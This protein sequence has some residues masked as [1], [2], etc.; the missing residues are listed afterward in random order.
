MSLFTG[1][2]TPATDSAPDGVAA[3]SRLSRSALFAANSSCR[4][5]RVHAAR[6][7]TR[8]P[9]D[10]WTHRKRLVAQAHQRSSHAEHSFRRGWRTRGR[11]DRVPRARSAS[12]AGPPAA[13][14]RRVE[15][16]MVPPGCHGPW[17]CSSEAEDGFVV[18][19]GI[20]AGV[21]E[22]QRD[23][24]RCRRSHRIGAPIN[25]G[26]G[27]CNPDDPMQSAFLH[28]WHTAAIELP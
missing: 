8:W 16:L 25:T 7:A 15:V 26:K 18:G 20:G 5:C 24:Q 10:P 1:L 12:S 22:S 17:T 19:G 21:A 28:E 13:R 23:R 14:T 6:L 9:R 4:E 27:P 3:Q 11:Q 2:L